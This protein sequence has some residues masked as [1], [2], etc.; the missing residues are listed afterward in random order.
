MEN[1]KSGLGFDA[2]KAFI[3]KAVKLGK[4]PAN[5]ASGYLAAL[6]T[7]ER[8][9][10]T[11]EPKT[12]EYLLSHLEELFVRQSDLQLSPQS[13]PVYISRIKKVCNDFNTYGT[14][15][16]AIYRWNRTIR[17]KALKSQEAKEVKPASNDM[18]NGSESSENNFSQN[19]Q[20]SNGV[21]LNTVSWRL[22]PGVV[23]RIELP[24]DLNETDVKKIKA[25]LN[26]ELGQDL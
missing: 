11:E 10:L 17:K 7:V 18:N 16:T 26:I 24:E 8:A 6:K 12:I 19:Q 2:L 21:K 15:A 23:I 9:F 1:K 25:L 14:D 4:Y 3:E 20:V 22:R 5:T 13:V